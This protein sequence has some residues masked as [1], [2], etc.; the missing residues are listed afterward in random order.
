MTF[1][2]VKNLHSTISFHLTLFEEQ[3]LFVKSF[4][5]RSHCNSSLEADHRTASLPKEKLLSQNFS[6]HKATSPHSQ[7]LIESTPNHHISW[8]RI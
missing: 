1:Y 7:T 5:K 6:Y 8:L 3:I 2:M 4:S